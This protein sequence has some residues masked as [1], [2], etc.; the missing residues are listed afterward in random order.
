M[1]EKAPQWFTDMHDLEK[2]EL[3]WNFDVADEEKFCDVFMSCGDRYV[4]R[5]AVEKTADQDRLYYF[6]VNDPDAGVRSA[7]AVRLTD[8]DRLY[9]IVQ[10]DP[11]RQVRIDA[12][13]TLTD[14][15]MLY[16]LASSH[17]DRWIRKAAILS[18]KDDDDLVMTVFSEAEEN[19]LRLLAAR[20]VRDQECLKQI[21]NSAEQ[22]SSMDHHNAI[23]ESADLRRAAVLGLADHDMLRALA[24][25]YSERVTVRIAAVSKLGEEDRDILEMIAAKPYDPDPGRDPD[26]YYNPDMK[27]AAVAKLTDRELLR[28]YLD[29]PDQET[30]AA[31]RLA[32]GDED[33]LKDTV[34]DRCWPP[35]IRLRALKKITDRDFLYDFAM[36][37]V[38][39]DTDETRIAVAAAKMIYS[40][41]KLA[42]LAMGAEEYSVSEAAVKNICYDD[43]QALR[44]IREIKKHREKWASSVDPEVR[45]VRE[46]EIKIAAAQQLEDLKPLVWLALTD[47]GDHYE[48]NNFKECAI[49]LLSRDPDLMLDYVR[50]EKDEW[51]LTLAA[52]FSVDEAVLQAIADK[53]LKDTYAQHKLNNLRRIGEAGL[54]RRDEKVR[55]WHDILEDASEV[56][57][58]GFEEYT[59]G[60]RLCRA[61]LMLLWRRHCSVYFAVHV[62][63]GEPYTEWDRCRKIA[64][65]ALKMAVDDV[66]NLGWTSN[67]RAEL[68][69]YDAECAAGPHEP[70]EVE[71]LLPGALSNIR[72][73]AVLREA[74]AEVRSRVDYVRFRLYHHEDIMKD[75]AEAPYRSTSSEPPPGLD[76]FEYID[77][78]ISH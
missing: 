58:R 45:Y 74:K 43:D 34:T 13:A 12:A 38:C 27:A 9:G 25:D 35:E 63:D 32:L 4:R 21:I 54:K 20:K 70:S 50:R 6:A 44:I 76:E 56:G 40:P 42:A 65:Q 23:T 67:E 69:D 5:G 71:A 26:L 41:E 72:D 19:E 61:K 24:S 31:A 59:E 66:M 28:S 51:A 3:L 33:I 64:S 68:R 17:P 62:S 47:P 10:N 73:E 75:K 1:S 37:H 55:P 30:R 77:W 48:I 14:R 57:V 8:N 16:E 53:G 78:V 46:E 39:D 52:N 49:G 60:S 15:E 18:I 11:D 36:R 7:A 22:L 2:K 29:D